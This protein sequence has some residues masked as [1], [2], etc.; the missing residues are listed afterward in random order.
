VAPGSLVI[1]L[2]VVAGTDVLRN[3]RVV[4]LTMSTEPTCLASKSRRWCCSLFRVAY[5]AWSSHVGARQP[6]FTSSCLH[7][8]VPLVSRNRSVG[9]S[10]RYKRIPATL[11]VLTQCLYA[12]PMARKVQTRLDLPDCISSLIIPKGDVRYPHFGTQCRQRSSS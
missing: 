10:K 11:I 9:L 5:A 1:Y 6:G 8:L 3:P 4:P 12:C 7:P 2:W